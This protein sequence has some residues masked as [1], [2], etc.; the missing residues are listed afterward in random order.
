MSLP[1]RLNQRETSGHRQ[2]GHGLGSIAVTAFAILASLAAAVVADATATDP[3]RVA[4]VFPPWWSEARAV[5]VAASAG[6]ILGV[7]G[8]PFV[9]IVHRDPT[10]VARHARAV[11]ALFVLGAD[12]RSL[13][14]FGLSS[15]KS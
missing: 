13:C 6:D 1:V 4:L 3:S 5:S 14:S 7:G 8:V 10:T 12:P 11:G 2:P 15:S 9:V